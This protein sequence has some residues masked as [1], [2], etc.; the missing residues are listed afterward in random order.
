MVGSEIKKSHD[1]NLTM[2]HIKKAMGFSRPW[3]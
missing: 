3:P 2:A 1:E